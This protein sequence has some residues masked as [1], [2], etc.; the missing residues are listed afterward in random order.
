M[1]FCL[2]LIAASG[3]FAQAVDAR[4]LE[5]RKQYAENYLKP[6]AHFA[7]AQ[8]HLEKGNKLQAFF[9]MEF[10]RRYKFP[11]ELFDTAFI[12]FFGV[13]ED[14]DPNAKAAFDKGY[15]LLKQNKLNEAASS[16]TAAAKLAPKSAVV[17]TWVG[18]F[19]YKAKSDNALALQYYFNAYFLHPH[20]YETEFVESRIRD[21]TVTD[22]DA[23]FAKLLKSGKTLPEIAADANPL[24][25]HRAID[26]M[27]QQWKSEYRNALLKCLENDDDTLRWMAF[28]A[29]VKNADAATRDET[30]STLFNSPDLRKKGL[31][32]YALIEF[33][34]EK[35][36]EILERMLGDK[37]ELVRFDAISA[38][39]MKGGERGREIVR[40][41]QKAEPS[42]LLRDLIIQ[43]LSEK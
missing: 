8:Y 12:K 34:K 37:A 26:R 27:A 13:E 36:F 17:Q 19:F 42:P 39:M 35:S 30:I 3:V 24:L 20:A 2:L 16:F 15:E 32:A 28:E 1:L 22:A 33:Q 41:H 29:L 31:S 23:Q 6:E 11:E 21:I 25:A 18:R 40:R 7:L 14:P 5:L 38:L 9:I 10:A 4:L 43:G